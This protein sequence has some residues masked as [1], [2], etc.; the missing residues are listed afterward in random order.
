MKRIIRLLIILVIVLIVGAFV[1]ARYVDGA[2]RSAVE[3]AA[4]ESLG[5]ETTLEGMKIGIL[6]SNCTM[7]GLRVANPEGFAGDTFLRMRQG[8]IDVNLGTLLD[9]T[10]EIPELTLDGIDVNIVLD[11]DRGNYDVIL[12]NMAKD[13]DAEESSRKYIVRNL[14]IREVNVQATLS[15]LAAVT[16]SQGS[17]VKL[18]VPEIVLKDVGSGGKDGVA[19]AQLGDTIVQAILGAVA[20]H[21]V[22]L[23]QRLLDDLKGGLVNL[24]GFAELELDVVGNVEKVLEQS[25]G[26]AVEGAGKALDDA[27]K[28]IGNMF[29]K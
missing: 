2:A 5:V 16:G 10:V 29:G 22:G 21:G 13:S 14:R 18:T 17:L 23:P 7:D 8:H 27:S 28:K 25:L 24:P 9:D 19:L 12:D 15:P 20:K 26:G 3:S 6:D 1:G 11:G 4:T